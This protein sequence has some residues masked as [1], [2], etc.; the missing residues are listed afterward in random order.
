MDAGLIRLFLRFGFWT[1]LVTAVLPG[2]KHA[3]VFKDGVNADTL[4]R[5][6]ELSMVDFANF[7]A[8]NPSVCQT[9]KSVAANALEQ[10]KTGV[11]TA[12]QGV[13]TQFDEPDRETITSGIR[14]E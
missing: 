12:Y 11:L 13:R 5:A 6:L 10:A 7:C 1:L 9:G 14:K 3:D 8:R 2:L 4:S